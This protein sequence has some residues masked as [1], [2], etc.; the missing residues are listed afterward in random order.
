MAREDED[1]IPA[2][3]RRLDEAAWNAISRA[4]DAELEQSGGAKLLEKL[5]ALERRI[6]DAAGAD[7]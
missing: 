1:F 5:E 6:E 4:I 7:G 3:E 2:A